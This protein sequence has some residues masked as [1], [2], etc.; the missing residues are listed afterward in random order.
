[1]QPTIL[2]L[3]FFFMLITMSASGITSFSVVALN[4]MYGTPL[5]VGN[6]ALTGYLVTGALGVLLGGW[7]ADRTRHH[8]FVA[9]ACFAAPLP[10]CCCWAQSTSAR[11]CWWW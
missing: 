3:M 6:T 11:H 5:A 9:A 10:S 1:M 2:G 8:A 4:S 7:I